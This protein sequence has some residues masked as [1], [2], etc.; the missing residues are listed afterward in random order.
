LLSFVNKYITATVGGDVSAA[1]PQQD[2]N[3]LLLFCFA[4]VTGTE[5]A[6]LTSTSPPLWV[7]TC[8]MWGSFGQ[9]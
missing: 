4:A 1:N 8:S 2:L 6:L 3:L 5:L 9:T 7:V